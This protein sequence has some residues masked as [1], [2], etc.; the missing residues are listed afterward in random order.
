[1][2][3]LLRNH[4]IEVGFDGP[5]KRAMAAVDPAL[6]D[7]LAFALIQST[8]Q[9]IHE[10]DST[11]T[12]DEFMEDCARIL[13]PGNLPSQV[14]E[15]RTRGLTPVLA[16]LERILTGAVQDLP[17]A[18]SFRTSQARLRVVHCAGANLVAVLLS[19]AGT[20]LGIGCGTPEPAWPAICPAAGVVGAAF[21]VVA[22]GIGIACG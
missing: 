5:F 17:V 3:D 16:D 18:Y 15:L 11:F 10:A 21:G 13:Q 14:E 6:L 4:F 22:L 7:P 12:L 8:Y 19:A 2:I 20:T 9:A 1:M